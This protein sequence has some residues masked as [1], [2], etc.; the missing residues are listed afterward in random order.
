[1]A[2]K[3]RD[4]LAGGGVVRSLLSGVAVAAL[5]FGAWSLYQMTSEEEAEEPGLGPNTGAMESAGLRVRTTPENTGR[6]DAEMPGNKQFTVSE[7]E[8]GIDNAGWS[9]AQRTAFTAQLYSIG[10]GEQFSEWQM[11]EA[12]QKLSPSLPGYVSE[13]EL[14]GMI[15]VLP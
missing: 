15:A 9:E 8:Q 12:R 2:P 1:V 5:A 6:S 7:V 3:N 11:Y 13:S 14:A 4:Q 10:Q